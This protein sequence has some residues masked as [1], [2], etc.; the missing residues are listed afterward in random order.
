MAREKNKS[1]WTP[2]ARLSWPSLFKPRANALDKSGTLKYECTLIFDETSQRDPLFA[3]MRQ[4]A[5]TAAFLQ[6]GNAIPANLKR[7]LHDGSEKRDRDG[8]I[9]EGFDGPGIKFMNVSCQADKHKPE[10]RGLRNELITDPGILYA[11]CYVQA[12]VHAYGYVKGS[13]GVA[14]GLDHV[15]MVAH[16]D[17]FSSS[18]SSSEAFGGPASAGVPGPSQGEAGGEDLEIPF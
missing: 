15:K 8:K 18:V 3:A 17:R 2:K 7:A 5:S 4:A 13:N 16:G 6:W 12:F 14:F 1:I 11:G 10:I 9:L